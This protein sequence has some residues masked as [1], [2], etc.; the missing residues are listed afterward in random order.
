MMYT[1]KRGQA[2]ESNGPEEHARGPAL[3]DSPVLFTCLLDSE[4]IFYWMD[5]GCEADIPLGALGVDLPLGC[6]FCC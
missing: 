2:A 3:G 1:R 4:D 6:R 5:T